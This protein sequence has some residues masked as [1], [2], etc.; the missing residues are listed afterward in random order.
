MSAGAPSKRAR[1][2]VLILAG[3]G[4]IIGGFAWA[5]RRVDPEVMMPRLNRRLMYEPRLRS[6]AR[7]P[8]QPGDVVFLGD[9]ITQMAKW[10]RLFPNVA[11]ANRG[12]SGDTT[13]GLL[14]RVAEIA[15]ARPS[16]VFILI[17][18]N[19]LS[20][21]KRSDEEIVA[22]VVAVVDAIR[23]DTPT[24]AIHVQ[25]IMPRRRRWR[26]RVERV[27]AALEPAVTARGAA[28]IDLWPVFDDGT[29]QLRGELTFDRLHPRR[30]GTE[31]WADHLRPWVERA[32]P[33]ASP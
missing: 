13:D 8:L 19:D 23:A 16:K 29:G 7:E 10:D 26:A 30:R 22:N 14:A 9:S 17:G 3:V 6:F 31:E 18:T 11:V 20:V 2:V 33:P 12:I 4:T 1:R 28:W 32:T 27:N 15:G 5:I 24:A 21:G 25:S